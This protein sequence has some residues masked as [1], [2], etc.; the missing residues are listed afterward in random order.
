MSTER[1]THAP[2]RVAQS[3]PLTLRGKNAATKIENNSKI[4]D[5]LGD[6]KENDLK[7]D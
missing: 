6:S 1:V 3:A 2:S 4:F 5:A 7:I